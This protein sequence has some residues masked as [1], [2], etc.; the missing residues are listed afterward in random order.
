MGNRTF[1][2][3]ALRRLAIFV[4]ALGMVT[5]SSGLALMTTATAT[6][7]P[8]QESYWETEPGETCTKT[9]VGA[10]SGGY[11]VPAAPEGYEWSKLII[12]KGS[13]NIGVENQVFEDPVAGETYT[14]VGFESEQ[15]GGWSHTILCMVP[16]VATAEISVT[17][18]DCDNQNTP[19]IE[20]LGTNVVLPFDVDGTIAPGETVTVTATAVEGALFDGGETTMVFD[21]VVFGE[22]EADCDIVNPP[23]EVTPVAPGFVDPDCATEAQ[24]TTT[25]VDGVLYEVSGDVVPGGTVEVTASAIEP[26]VFAEGA[27]TFWTHTF[28][29]VTGCGEVLPPSETPTV[30]PTVVSAGLLPGGPDAAGDRG[31]V[32][33]VTGMLLMLV[34]GGLGMVRPGGEVRS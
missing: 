22:A 6:V 29:E 8:N 23:E 19:A 13:G 2:R 11:T 4:A 10:E 16:F 14:W 21:D 15:S 28:A 12:K 3:P 34:A 32:L 30:T 9:D 20:F 25:D 33:L 27:E 1:T 17:Q 24:V 5:V 31:L 18:P 26:A 7:G